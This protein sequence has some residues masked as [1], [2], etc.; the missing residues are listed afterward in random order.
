MF[1]DFQDAFNQVMS[2]QQISINQCLSMYSPFWQV[3]I[4]L[5]SAVALT[6]YL[7]MGHIEE[8]RNED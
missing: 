8:L 3:Q 1:Q 7:Q 5:S 6:C 4:V 2:Y